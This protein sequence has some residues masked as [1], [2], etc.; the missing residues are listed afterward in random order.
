M[1]QILVGNDIC[2]DVIQELHKDH[3]LALDTETEGLRPYLDHRL[4]SIIISNKLD[5]YYFNFN[6]K[7]DHLGNYV[8]EDYIIPMNCVA[9][10]FTGLFEDL[11]RTVYMHNA[12]FD[13]HFLSQEGIQIKSRVVCT[14]AMSRLVHNMLP[15]YKLEKLGELIGYKKMIL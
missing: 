15:S 10:F 1:A 14:Q 2:Y 7:A 8:P 4:F 9:G 12:K 6:A 3:K 13:M 11:E 5:D